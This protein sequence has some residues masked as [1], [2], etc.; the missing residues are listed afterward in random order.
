[1]WKEGEASAGASLA[2]EKRAML[3]QRTS[4]EGEAHYSSPSSTRKN[5]RPICLWLMLHTP[6][7]ETQFTVVTPSPFLLLRGQNGFLFIPMGSCCIHRGEQ[8]SWLIW[9]MSR[10]VLQK[11][12]ACLLGCPAAAECPAFGNKRLPGN[13]QML[14]HG[15]GLAPPTRGSAGREE[16]LRSSSTSTMC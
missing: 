13:S 7:P 15:R 9:L 12:L 4:S 14:E 6:N 5:R 11:L 1:M 8:H 2:L 10:H 16:V 3:G